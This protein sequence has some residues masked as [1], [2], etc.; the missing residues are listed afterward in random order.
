MSRRPLAHLPSLV[1][2]CRKYVSTCS[3]GTTETWFLALTVIFF[4][5][6]FIPAARRAAR[7]IIS[8]IPPPVAR[9]RYSMPTGGRAP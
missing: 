5:A 9:G 4:G 8:V 2:S 7:F 3:I 6:D 1:I